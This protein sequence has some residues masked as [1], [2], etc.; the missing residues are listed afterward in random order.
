MSAPPTRLLILSA[1]DV[2]RVLDE[3]TALES[4]R[5][6]FRALGLGHAQ[7]PAR[8][9]MEGPDNTSTFCY[10][11]QVDAD[12]GAVCKFGAVR[13]G[14]VAR[15]LPSI[16][17]V[18]VVLDPETGR[19]AAL[20]DGTSVTTIRTS[21]ASAVAAEHLTVPQSSVLAVI[22]SGVQAEA[23]VRLMRHV[24]PLRE[25]RIFGRDGQAS[26]RL[27]ARLRDD[28]GLDVQSVATSAAAVGGAQVVVTATSS[29]TP[30]LDHAD[31]DPG[32][33]VIS[34]GS[35]AAERCEIPRE[36]VLAAE[37]VVVDHREVAAEHA[38]PIVQ[39]VADGLLD[40]GDVVDLGQVVTGQHPGR[41]TRTGIVYYNSV[42]IGVQDAAAASLLVPRAWGLGL[43][44]AVEL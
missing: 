22:G 1:Q 5:Q 35:Y 34:V 10:A 41:R 8:I 11:A 26:A 19:P 37:T 32:T 15:G 16:S 44:Q 18:I 12:S 25:V 9:L 43:G 21:A 2:H 29:Q 27:A 20:V 28:L 23:H 33:T 17:A 30:V 6:A 7:Q 14:N 31:L 36:T 3:P 13:P 4:Q 42:G 24:L 39:A 38:G 40:P